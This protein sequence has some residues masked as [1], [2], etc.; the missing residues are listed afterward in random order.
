MQPF[1]SGYSV[2]ITG[3]TNG[4]CGNLA[5]DLTVDLDNQVSSVSAD[6]GQHCQL[7]NAHGCAT[8]GEGIPA[9]SGFIEYPGIQDFS[10]S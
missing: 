2:T 9:W 7:F 3:P 4:R 6:Q 8:S 5:V 1:F 10:V